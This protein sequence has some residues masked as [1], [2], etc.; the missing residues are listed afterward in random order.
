MNKTIISILFSFLI[1]NSLLGQTNIGA[2]IDSDLSVTVGNAYPIGTFDNRETSYV[3][4]PLLWK[5]WMYGN[6]LLRGNK[7]YSD[8][9]YRFN[10]NALD[11]L[12]Y[13]RIGDSVYEMMLSKVNCLDVITDVESKT[14]YKVLNGNSSNFSLYKVVYSDDM[15]ELVKS[16]DVELQ[17]SYYNAA[18]DAGDVRPK[19]KKSDK[20]YIFKNDQLF[21]LPKKR[22]KLVDKYGRSKEMK[23]IV[24][25]FDK[26]R[27][28]LKSEEE[29]RSA[30]INFKK[31]I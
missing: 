4:S 26:N 5:D 28:D 1:C 21:E 17:E 18:L 3:G 19:L 2:N 8:R 22:K 6:I 14:L 23:E 31:N 30:L 24:A 29:I 13:I 10:Y 25:F 7:K 27:V 11:N 15:F 16:T 12:L 20:L 9:E